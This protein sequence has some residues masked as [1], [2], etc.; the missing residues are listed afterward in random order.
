[1]HLS[2]A[3][4]PERQCEHS[5]VICNSRCIVEAHGDRHDDNESPVTSRYARGAPKTVNEV[6][7]AKCCDDGGSD[8]NDNDGGGKDD[9][10]NV[11]RQKRQRR[12]QHIRQ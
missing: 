1:M 7:I 2:R 5:D 6:L 11:D 9:N 10:G 8:Y 4:T 12:Q 3:C